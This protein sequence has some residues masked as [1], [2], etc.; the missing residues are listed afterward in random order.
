MVDPM[1]EQNMRAKIVEV[2]DKYAP[3]NTGFGWMDTID[4]LG[5]CQYRR[6]PGRF[7]IQS[8]ILISFLYVLDA[9]WED[10]RDTL[11]HE[12]AH[13]K[14]PRDGHS[15]M[16][17]E[18]CIS[19]GGDGETYAHK[20]YIKPRFERFC[21]VCGKIDGLTKYRQHHICHDHDGKYVCCDYRNV[22]EDQIDNIET[23]REN[24]GLIHVCFDKEQKLREK[25]EL[26]PD[27]YITELCR[28]LIRK[29]GVKLKFN[30]KGNRCT[31]GDDES[32]ITIDT[33]IYSVVTARKKPA[34]K[35]KK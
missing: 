28:E 20:S 29:D 6:G 30:S 7:C 9:P 31:L 12:I 11:A 33:L 3:E 23:L 24:I 26:D 18:V 22:V 17:R 19:L 32:E 35:S 25:L 16:W 1:F 21:P 27:V 8:D 5:Q 15:P 4:K 14:L 13:A 2:I 34:K 10:V